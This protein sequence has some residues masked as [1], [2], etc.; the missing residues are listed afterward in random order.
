MH[1]DT[2]FL[3]QGLVKYIICVQMRTWNTHIRRKC[4]REIATSHTI[5]LKESKEIS[6]HI[7]AQYAL[8]SLGRLED[9][10][11]KGK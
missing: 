1:Y 10:L 11:C 4:K 3:D 7:Y 9:I 5:Y 2:L 6:C 8:I